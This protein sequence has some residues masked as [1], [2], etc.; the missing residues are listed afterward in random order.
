MAFIDF[1]DAPQALSAPA[2]PASRPFAGTRIARFD[3]AL[4]ALERRVVEMA[5]VDD[6]GSLRPPR[7][8]GWLARLILGPTPASS[9]LANERLEALRRL[10]VHG[11]H[12]GYRLPASAM[13][14][15]QEAGYSEQ[16]VGAVIDFIALSRAP[17]RRL[18]A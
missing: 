4:S 14:E 18:A 5:R 12:E 7:K 17:S 16:Q 15:A 1:D 13:K 10:A 8:R 6:L 11:W 3:E 9:E 2:L